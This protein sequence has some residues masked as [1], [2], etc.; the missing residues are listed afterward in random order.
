MY[1]EGTRL[2]VGQGKSTATTLSTYALP[3]QPA[4][5]GPRERGTMANTWGSNYNGCIVVRVHG[6]PK[7]PGETGALQEREMR[8]NEEG[9]AVFK[10]PDVPRTDQSNRSC[11]MSEYAPP[12]T[13]AYFAVCTP[14]PTHHPILNLFSDRR[15]RKERR[16]CFGCQ[17]NCFWATVPFA[18]L[19]VLRG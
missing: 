10:K 6:E 3:G 7:A 17:M 9:A 5:I 19:C 1:A 8:T 14:S 13:Q 18:R 11:M 12:R 4:R 2:Q 15:T 16:C